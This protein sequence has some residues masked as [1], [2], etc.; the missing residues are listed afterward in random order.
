MP[1]P[2]SPRRLDVWLDARKVGELREQGNLWTFAYER[3]WQASGF[4]LSPA[5]RRADGEIVDG[6]RLRP[7][8][9][10]R[11]RIGRRAHPAGPRPGA[12]GR[13]AG[14]AARRGP[15]RTDPCAAA[16]AAVGG[17]AQTDVPGRGPAQAGRRAAPGSPVGARWPG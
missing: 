10:L 7:A 12:A 11:P 8:A 4:D 1:A 2:P 3:E 14:T 17:R 16:A 9:A 6:A 15:V 5:L 13:A